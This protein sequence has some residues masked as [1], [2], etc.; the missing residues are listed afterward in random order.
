MKK[1]KAFIVIFTATFLLQAHAGGA[2]VDITLK[3]GR[4]DSE[5]P[6]K[7]I[8]GMKSTCTN[9]D[10]DQFISLH[11]NEISTIFMEAPNKAEIV[12]MYCDAIDTI[13]Q[14][15]DSTPLSAR[16]SLIKERD[17]SETLTLCI[18]SMSGSKSC[19]YGFDVIIEDGI[20]KKDEF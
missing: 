11:S 16:Y 6:A 1:Y 18:D 14:D 4:I 13:F 20:L 8:N 5:L 7:L 15:I 12:S 10:N 3:P 9:G 17:S 2:E 19:Q